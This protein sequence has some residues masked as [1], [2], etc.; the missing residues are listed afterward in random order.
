MSL[1]SERSTGM[2]SSLRMDLG[3]GSPPMPHLRRPAAEMVG[4]EEE[5]GRV[6]KQ[7]M[8]RIQDMMKLCR[9]YQNWTNFQPIRD[10]PKMGFGVETRV[11]GVEL[12]HG[13]RIRPGNQRGSVGFNA[14]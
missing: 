1:S 7:R 13:R 3:E 10:L 12:N 8:A 11:G 6:E 4:D 2:E 14:C 9:K 5:D